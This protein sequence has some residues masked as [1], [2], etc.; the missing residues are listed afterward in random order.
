MAEVRRVKRQWSQS[1]TDDAWRALVEEHNQVV[2]DMET[3]AAATDGVSA[4]DLEAKQI[5]TIEHGEP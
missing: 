4:G 3:L 2:K 5:E 1:P